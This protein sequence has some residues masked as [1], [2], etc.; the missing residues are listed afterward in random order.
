MFRC[1]HA[2]ASVETRVGVRA[3][4]FAGR[5]GKGAW[6]IKP[7][8]PAKKMDQ[9]TSRRDRLSNIFAQNLSSLRQAT[10]V[11]MYAAAEA[12]GVSKSTWSQWESGKRF[13][14]GTML[15]AI[16]DCL[17]VQPCALLKD[18]DMDC[19]SIHL[20]TKREP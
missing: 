8:M 2:S 20:F 15:A 17:R 13:P 1:R 11:K 7:I 12:L 4:L 5:A 16:A 14:G 9:R 6:I 3:S 10:G 19:G 18:P